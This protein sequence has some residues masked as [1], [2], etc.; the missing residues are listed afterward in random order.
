M[1]ENFKEI[2]SG[3]MNNYTI[4]I[5]IYLIIIMLLIHVII[6]YKT[7]KK[8]N[9][10]FKIIELASLEDK[11]KENTVEEPIRKTKKNKIKK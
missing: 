10:L 7:N 1:L 11:Q 3:Y 8:V 6:I 2:A 4:Y 9:Q 5:G